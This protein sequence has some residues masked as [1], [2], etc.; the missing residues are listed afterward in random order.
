MDGERIRKKD[1]RKSALLG[2]TGSWHAN[3]TYV[4]WLGRST[5]RE[6]RTEQKNWRCMNILP[7]RER[8]SGT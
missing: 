7:L 2:Q 5:L 6:K 3:T 1:S 8:N 4:F